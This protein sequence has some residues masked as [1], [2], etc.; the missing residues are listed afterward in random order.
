MSRKIERRFLKGFIR[1][2]IE[3]RFLKEFIRRKILSAKDGRYPQ[4]NRFQNVRPWGGY[5]RK[6]VFQ[7]VVFWHIFLTVHFKG[8][9]RMLNLGWLKLFSHN[10]DVVSFRIIY[11]GPERA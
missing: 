5:C 2:K 1:R 11:I 8:L 7:K 10:S 3:R 6:N 9:Y 4:N